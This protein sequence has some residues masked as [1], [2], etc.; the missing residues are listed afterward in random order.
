MYKILFA[1][2]C[3]VSILY[4]GGC[5]SLPAKLPTNEEIQQA[6]YGQPNG[7]FSKGDA[8][9][10]AKVLVTYD[11]KDPDSAKYIVSNMYPGY[12]KS[13]FLKDGKVHYGYLL[14]VD[15]NAKNSYGGYTGYKRNRF[16]FRN[17]DLIGQ[18]LQAFCAINGE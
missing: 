10:I 4:L 5:A 7:G 12:M 18:C 14:D 6:D 3:F 16:L 15:V 1:L 8:E 9:K 13:S 11:L 17:G 2:V